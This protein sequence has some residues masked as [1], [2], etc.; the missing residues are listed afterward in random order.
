MKELLLAISILSIKLGDANENASK[1]Q[2]QNNWLGFEPA[3]KEEVIN[4]EKRLNIILPEDY[5]EFLKITNGFSA[6]NTVEPTF[7]KVEDVDFLKNIDPEFVEI[8]GEGD[9]EIDRV[10]KK[11]ILI[12][13]KDQEQQFLLIPPD[14]VKEKW[15]YW[16]FA[17]W[18]AGEYEFENLNCYFKD[19]L[20]FCEKEY[21]DRK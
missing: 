14:N 15:R 13:G 5:K 3:K 8:W 4:T 6:P 21:N 10:L 2:I 1:I 7:M 19:V 9:P 20:E 11:S 12:A 18:Q 16:K 17:N